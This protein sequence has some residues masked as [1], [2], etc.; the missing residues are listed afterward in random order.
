MENGKRIRTQNPGGYLGKG[1]ISLVATLL[2]NSERPLRNFLRRRRCF[3]LISSAACMP[4][5]TAVLMQLRRKSSQNFFHFAKEI[6]TR[7]SRN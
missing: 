1:A 6:K 7:K 5:E 3:S 4:A 2:G